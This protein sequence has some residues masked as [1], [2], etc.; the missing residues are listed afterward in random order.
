MVKHIA[1]VMQAVEAARI[2]IDEGLTIRTAVERFGGRRNSV[3]DARLIL[4]YGTDNDLKDLVQGNVA[5]E[6]VARRVRDSLPDNERE[7]EVRKRKGV[8]PIEHLQSLKTDAM[9]WRKLSDTL[10]NLNSFPAPVDLIEVVH[11]NGL[12]AGTVNR[13]L[14]AASKWLE[15]FN[16]EWNKQL[17]SEDNLTDPGGGNTAS[18]TQH[19]KS[20]A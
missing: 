15:D 18:G 3:G 19:P 9:L 10:Q 7:L 4:Q 14:N 5:L 13:Y 16:N 1:N 8:M 20:A 17:V 12:R 11:R 6:K 2:A